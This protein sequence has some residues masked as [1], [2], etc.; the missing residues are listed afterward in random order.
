MN[1]PALMPQAHVQYSAFQLPDKSLKSNSVLCEGKPYHKSTVKNHRS[2]DDIN[3][4]SY[5]EALCSFRILLSV[6]IQ[7]KFVEDCKLF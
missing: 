3:V 6:R 4:L 7:R 2:E 1:C 5:E